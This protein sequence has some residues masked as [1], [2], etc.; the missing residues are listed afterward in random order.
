MFVQNYEYIETLQG[1][2][3]CIQILQ[4]DQSFYLWCQSSEQGQSP[5]P[6]L[7][8]LAVAMPTRYVIYLKL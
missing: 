8:S 4:M 3:I 7:T 1:Q 5:R 2:Q 6:L